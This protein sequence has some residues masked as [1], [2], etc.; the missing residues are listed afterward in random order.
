MSIP[1]KYVVLVS[2][3]RNWTDKEV[4]RFRLL[5][6]NPTLVVVGG[7]KFADDP[8]RSADEL[9][10]QVCEEEGIPIHIE[11]ANWNKYGKNAGS[12]RNGKMLSDWKPDE[13]ICFWDGKSTGTS[14]MINAAAGLGIKLQVNL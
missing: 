7:H 4:I 1:D 9:T 2:G 12:I 8:N 10:R 3:S 5:E 14:N 11:K 6:A 13:V